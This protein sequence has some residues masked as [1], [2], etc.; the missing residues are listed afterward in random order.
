MAKPKLKLV[1]PTAVNRTVVPVRRPNK[2]LRTRE[3]LTQAEVDRLIEAAKS[4]RWGHRDSTM[5]L[6]A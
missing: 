3:H 1:S 2:D 4:N 5:I 6:L